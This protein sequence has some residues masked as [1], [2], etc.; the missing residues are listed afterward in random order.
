MIVTRHP[1]DWQDLIR[2]E[3]FHNQQTAVWVTSDGEGIT[4]FRGLVHERGLFRIHPPV[5]RINAQLITIRYKRNGFFRRCHRIEADGYAPVRRSPCRPEE[6]YV[7]Q[8]LL[9]Y[10]IAN[11][12][13]SNHPAGDAVRHLP[14]QF[15]DRSSTLTIACQHKG[16]ALIEMRQ[17][18]LPTAL[19]VL[20]GS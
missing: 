19:H 17:V 16:P 7:S 18:I 5:D 1:N 12:I 6:R 3:S 20:N 14:H 11:H 8:I 4:L 2:L 15:H 10:L 13:G 9:C